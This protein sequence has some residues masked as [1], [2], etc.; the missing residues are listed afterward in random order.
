MHF[1][2]ST[3]L[4]REYES[5]G[6]GLKGSPDRK[7][8]KK[9][10]RLGGLFSSSL[11]KKTQSPWEQQQEAKKTRHYIPFSLGAVVLP[12]MWNTENPTTKFYSAFVIFQGKTMIGQNVLLELVPGDKVQVSKN[13]N[14][15]N[16]LFRKCA[17]R[18][19]SL[20]ARQSSEGRNPK[21][22]WPKIS[23]NK[24]IRQ[25]NHKI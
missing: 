21:T 9:S 16:T 12:C 14:I 6:R 23:T 4:W 3:C 19:Y 17:A 5:R 2:S 13:R 11:C 22:W 8:P 25:K 1:D 20:V 24:F 7:Q 10:Q 18:F 15:S